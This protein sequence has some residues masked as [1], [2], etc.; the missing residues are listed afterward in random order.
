MKVHYLS[1]YYTGSKGAKI[2]WTACGRLVKP[3][4]EKMQRID[5]L[6][7]LQPL[8]ARRA[9]DRVTCGSCLRSSEY[10]GGW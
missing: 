3:P 7:T 4:P 9:K 10:K 5:K 6:V 2:R 8:T 1:S